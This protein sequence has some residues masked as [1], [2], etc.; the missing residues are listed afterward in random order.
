M[1]FFDQRLPTQYS[2]GAKGGPAFSTEVVKSSGGQRFANKNWTMPL[3]QYDVSAAI[4]TQADFEVIRQFFYN[5]SG[6]FSGFRFK[7]YAD[8]ILT[9][10]TSSLALISGAVYQI[11]RIYPLGPRTFVR[12][13]Y[14]PVAS[15]ITV[16]RTRSSLV[17]VATAAIDYTTG[18]ATITGHVAGDTYTA[19]GQ[20]DVPVAF[21][22]DVLEAQ[23]SSKSGGQFVME[24]PSIQL[25][26]LRL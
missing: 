4:R 24:W 18:Q 6:Q 19:E 7:D 10:A 12:P 16:Y 20:F 2:F 8:F 13:I 23:I 3:H 25:E 26:E 21:L 17:T 9:Q 14:K 5:C 11:N 22:S 1:D 15:T